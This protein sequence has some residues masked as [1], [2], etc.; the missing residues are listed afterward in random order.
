MAQPF[1]ADGKRHRVCLAQFGL[2]HPRAEAHRLAARIAAESRNLLDVQAVTLDGRVVGHIF[3]FQAVAVVFVHI[4]HVHRR[5]YGLKC[6]A[7]IGKFAVHHI[8]VVVERSRVGIGI[9]RRRKRRAVPNGQRTKHAAQRF[10]QFVRLSHIGDI[11]IADKT[12]LAAAEAVWHQ[13]I[14]VAADLIQHPFVDQLGFEPPRDGRKARL[15]QHIVQNPCRIVRPRRFKAAVPHARISARFG[16]VIRGH[17]DF[18]PQNQI[19]AAR[20][21]AAELLRI[22]AQRGEGRVRIAQ[23]RV[24]DLHI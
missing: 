2:Q 19:I 1:A 7:A 22:D 4:L 15:R 14:T 20:L 5:V 8:A 16:V 10:N 9:G 23:T 21:T 11:H 6:R 24:D 17:A 18:A 12:R 3:G 13:L